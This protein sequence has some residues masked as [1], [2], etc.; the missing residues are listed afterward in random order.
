VLH[1][2]HQARSE[3][4]GINDFPVDQQQ[5]LFFPVPSVPSVVKGF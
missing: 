3:K 5:L 4:I 1:R 2:D